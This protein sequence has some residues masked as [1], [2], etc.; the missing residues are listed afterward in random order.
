ME[1]RELISTKSATAPSESQFRDLRLR[2]F[3]QSATINGV[4]IAERAIFT[5]QGFSLLTPPDRTS[6][7][8]IVAAFKPRLIEGRI[9]AS[10]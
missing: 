5:F 2:N 9:L 8:L 7:G 3:D 4:R 1:S 6:S 10:I